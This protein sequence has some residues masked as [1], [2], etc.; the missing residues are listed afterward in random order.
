MTIF[1][2]ILY[3]ILALFIGS[4]LNVV[5]LRVPLKQSIVTPG[6]HC[7][8]CGHALNWLD[9]LPLISYILFRGK[10]RYC[11][12][13]VS[14]IYFLG[15]LT[16][17]ILF[18]LIPIQFGLNLEMLIAYP[19]M[20]VLVVVLISD[21]QYKI[22]PDR[23]IIPGIILF[24]LM[25]L[26]IHPLPIW[27]YLIGAVGGGILLLLIAIVSRGGMGGGD[28]KLFFL[29][30]VVLGWQLMLLTLFIA[31]LLGTVIGGILLL[32]KR[33]KRGEPIAFGPFIV[34]A[35]VVAYF[36][37]NQIIEWYISIF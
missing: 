37:G 15:E 12:E 28:I 18:L 4:F 22:I 34:V 20:M 24:F 30:G 32:V 19:F 33:V 23:I 35:A 17:L 1:Y 14:P 27:D 29:L 2:I 21:L 16:T 13:K 5:A 10:C 26:F 3:I 6:S 25:R 7:P 9:L 8:N 36:W 11:N 31:A